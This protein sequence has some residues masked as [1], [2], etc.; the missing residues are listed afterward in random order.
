LEGTVKEIIGGLGLVIGAFVISL[1]FWAV[2][3]AATI[4]LVIGLLYLVGVL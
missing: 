3:V 4:G 2:G 1:L